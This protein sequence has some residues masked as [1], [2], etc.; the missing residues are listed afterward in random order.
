MSTRKRRVADAPA[1]EKEDEGNMSDTPYELLGA[2]SAMIDPPPKRPRGRPPKPKS[3]SVSSLKKK[4]EEPKPVGRPKKAPKRPGRPPK[5]AKP[6]NVEEGGSDAAADINNELHAQIYAL[7]SKLQVADSKVAELLMQSETRE[8]V[9]RN[10]EEELSETEKIRKKLH[11]EIMLLKGKVR[12]Y[13]RVRPFI[14]D[15]RLDNRMSTITYPK[16][17]EFK[18]C[19]LELMHKDQKCRF[20]FDKVFSEEASQEDVFVEVSPLIQSAL[21]GDKVHSF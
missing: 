16:S 5:P 13:C 20:K 17:M 14:P 3:T 15:N 1:A 6:V 4:T 7:N 18:G 2:T 12:V 8:E 9:I 19:S 21:D 10:L 11:N